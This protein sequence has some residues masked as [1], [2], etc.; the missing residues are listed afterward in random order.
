M[1][2]EIAIGRIK[3]FLEYDEI[4]GV[5]RWKKTKSSSAVAGNVAGTPNSNGHLQVVV[6][7]RAY[8]LHRLA[9]LYVH[10]RFPESNIDHING[11]PADNRIVNL[12]E[13]SQAMN[14]QN[15]R[16][17]QKN[18]KS[19]Y[20]GVSPARNKWRAR[21]DVNG[22]RIS[23]GV[24]EDPAQAYEAYLAAKRKMHDGCTI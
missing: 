21:I 15:L 22:D 3:E 6:D 10:G 18:N 7:G 11:N 19:G 24:F 23:L 13:A 8:F 4:T 17:A 2:R 9:W 5:F 16:R 14:M 20:L 12:R 1:K